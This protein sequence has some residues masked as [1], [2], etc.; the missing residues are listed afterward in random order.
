MHLDT[1]TA[2]SPI[3]GRYARKTE[4]LRPVF[5][6]YG[7]LRHRLLIEIRWLQTLSRCDDIAEVKPF[8]A[9]TNALL[10]NIPYNYNNRVSSAHHPYGSK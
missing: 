6:E 3:D 5:S 8:D 1:L 10:D 7:L 4:S 9:A 2:I